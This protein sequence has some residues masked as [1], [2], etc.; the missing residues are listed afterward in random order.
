MAGYTPNYGAGAPGNAR[1]T[2]PNYFSY[3]SNTFL[4]LFDGLPARLGAAEETP[5][6]LDPERY[7]DDYD[8]NQSNTCARLA[9]E[10]YNQQ[11]G[12]SPISLDCAKDSHKF[13]SNGTAYF[14]VNFKA[15]FDDCS[16]GHEPSFTFFAEVKGPGVPESVTMVIQLHTKEGRTRDNCLYCTGLKHPEQGGFVGHHRLPHHQI[17]DQAGGDDEGSSSDGE[18]GDEEDD[19]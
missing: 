4:D 13:F 2:Y 6:P 19:N 18:D 12:N 17:P 11:Q 8:G 15:T 10:F 16:R 7:Y 5:R 9:V 14:H 3:M 1:P